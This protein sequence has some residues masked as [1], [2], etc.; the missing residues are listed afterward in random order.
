MNPAG[1]IL[2]IDQLG[3][4]VVPKP[5]RTKLDLDLG[6]SIEVLSDNDGIYL[7]KYCVSCSLC[8]GDNNIVKFKEKAICEDCLK[9]I[10]NNF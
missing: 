10:K 4:I 7:K 6:D 5:L 2:K 3:R 8:G 1:F 9:E